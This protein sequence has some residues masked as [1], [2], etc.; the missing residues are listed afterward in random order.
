MTSEIAILYFSYKRP[1]QLDLAIRSNRLHC[2]EWQ[3]TDEFVI[4]K[5]DSKTLIDAY[6][7]VSDENPGIL[8]LKQARTPESFE[9]LLR[10]VLQKYKYVE[11]VV[12]DCIFTHDYSINNICGAL[13]YAK[14]FLGFSLRL[15]KNTKYCYSLSG[16]NHMPLMSLNGYNFEVFNWKQVSFGD[17]SYPLEVSSS[18]YKTEVIL[19]KLEKQN[20]GLLQNPNDLEWRLFTN[21]NPDIDPPFMMCPTTSVVF[22]NPVNKVNENNTNRAGSRIKYSVDYLTE[23]YMLDKRINPKIFDGWVSTGCHQEVEFRFEERK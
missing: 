1:V 3:T 9:F 15:G 21:L 20:R 8:F 22:C 12:D 23:V 19:E 6:Q 11:F 14:Q 17:F 7:K 16:E 4:F 10:M 2:A 5:A 13:K 18:V